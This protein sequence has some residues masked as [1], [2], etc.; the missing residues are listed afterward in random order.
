MMVLRSIAIRLFLIQRDFF[1]MTE[2]HDQA[3]LEIW[4]IGGT[5]QAAMAR[6][7]ESLPW[8]LIAS[9]H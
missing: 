4:G 3:G 1:G 9:V 6:W 2:S 7:R 8:F 5:H